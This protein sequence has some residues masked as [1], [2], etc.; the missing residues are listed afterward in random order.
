MLRDGEITDQAHRYNKK[1][2]RML[3]ESLRA[4]HG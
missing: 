3:R 1:Y 4:D 2:R